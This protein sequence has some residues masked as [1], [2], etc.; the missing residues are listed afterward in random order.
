MNEIDAIDKYL[1]KIGKGETCNLL[2]AE[3]TSSRFIRA[4]SERPA[5]TCGSFAFNQS[6]ETSLRLSP[7]SSQFAPA[8]SDISPTAVRSR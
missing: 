6:L 7:E 1:K 8:A 4:T 2:K 3:D 5:A